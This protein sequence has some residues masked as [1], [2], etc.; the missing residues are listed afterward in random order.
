MC[1]QARPRTT[2]I[3]RRF[4]CSYTV[5]A[6]DACIREAVLTSVEPL[7]Y[8]QLYIYNLV[9]QVTNFQY[10][11]G[12]MLQIHA[13]YST[14]CDIFNYIYAW[15]ARDKP[16]IRFPDIIKKCS[17]FSLATSCRYWR[18]PVALCSHNTTRVP[19]IPDRTHPTITHWSWGQTIVALTKPLY[20][21]SLQ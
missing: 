3:E 21:L 19:L 7:H 14:E 17:M 8:T 1:T 12:N 2:Y 10:C 9:C 13:A 11:Q 5:S 15:P 6:L 20:C 16:K 4:P 18:R